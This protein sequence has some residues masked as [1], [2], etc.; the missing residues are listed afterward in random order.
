MKADKSLIFPVGT[1][2]PTEAE[3]EDTVQIRKTSGRM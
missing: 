1:A 3:R 2:R